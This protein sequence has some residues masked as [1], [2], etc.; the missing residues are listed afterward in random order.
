MFLFIG[1]GL[2]DHVKGVGEAFTS[3]VDETL[4]STVD[5]VSKL[6]ESVTKNVEGKMTSFRENASFKARSNVL[7][8]SGKQQVNKDMQFAREKSVYSRSTFKTSTLTELK[9]DAKVSLNFT[10]C[11]KRTSRIPTVH[12]YIPV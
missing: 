3:G 8:K 5:D 7:S 6:Q 4:T 9:E 1:K 2:L 11:H 10:I 12:F